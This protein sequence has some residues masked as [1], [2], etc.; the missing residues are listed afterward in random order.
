MARYLQVSEPRG[1][2]T[3]RP[4]E[5]ANTLH[6]HSLPN[7]VDELHIFRDYR[8]ALPTVTSGSAFLIVFS[9]TG[10]G[11]TVSTISGDQLR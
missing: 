11:L 7:P 1:S 5:V 6:L 8:V 4:G 3:G 9:V 10:S 2:E